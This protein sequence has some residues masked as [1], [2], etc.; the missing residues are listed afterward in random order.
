MVA[1]LP[2]AAGA[3]TISS[4]DAALSVGQGGCDLRRLR[5]IDAYGLVGTACALRAARSSL[6]DVLPPDLAA[7]RSHLAT[8]GLRELP[9][10]ADG[11]L[12]DT[13][14]DYASDVVVPQVGLGLG[15]CAGLVESVVGAA[16]EPR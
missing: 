1:R 7:T 10:A 8:M 13:P 9:G 15:R 16:G 14:A 5:F 3:L 4:F 11:G 12:A 6:D 2:V